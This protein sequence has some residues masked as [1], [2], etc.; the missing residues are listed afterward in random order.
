VLEELDGRYGAH[1]QENFSLRISPESTHKMIDALLTNELL[2]TLQGIS[3]TSTEDLSKSPVSPTT[4]LRLRFDTDAST[5]RLLLRPSG[6][7]PKTKF[8]LEVVH[9]SRT[10]A[11]TLAAAC[12]AE[13]EQ[14]LT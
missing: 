8:Y 7:E 11:K 6:T 10:T 2:S 13:L 3:R 4:G 1:V 9:A 5:I 14:A 12:R